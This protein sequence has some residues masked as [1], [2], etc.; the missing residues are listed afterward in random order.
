[1]NEEQVLRSSKTSRSEGRSVRASLRRLLMTLRDSYFSTPVQGIITLIML[2]LLWK[3]L[4]AV[5]SWAVFNAVW[6]GDSKASAVSGGATW[7]FIGHKLRFFLY[8]FYP[9]E[10]IWRIHVA[11]VLVLIPSAALLYKRTPRRI[12]VFAS[13]ILILP[14]ITYLF[15]YGAGPL[16]K[17]GTQAWGGL[18]LTLILASM[19]LVFSFPIGLLLALGRR[20]ELP[21][22]RLCS[23]A[24]IEFFRGIPLI[25]ILFMS[26]VVVPFFLPPGASVDKILRI[27]IGMTCFQSAYLAEVIRGGLQSLDKGQ[28]E[29]ADALG[30]GFWM[31]SYLI[32][33]PQAL[34][35]VISNIG[36]ISISFLKDT[37]LVLII[38]MFDLLG[39]V[40]PLASDSDWLGMEP[41]GLIFAGLIYWIICF[42]VSRIS[43]GI[44]RNVNTQGV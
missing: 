2:F 30:F 12:L 39:I 20:S 43:S 13:L 21:V 27:I 33:L 36:S 37:T 38:G 1:M 3:V 25:T 41:E 6:T 32:I 31:K 29:A 5:L 22:L 8:G 44:E 34:K 10:E 9:A 26:S 15:I 23:V 11:A 14:V 17:V 40:T 42:A 16:E 7:A 28:Y 19:G 18:S 24:Y 35:A 4:S